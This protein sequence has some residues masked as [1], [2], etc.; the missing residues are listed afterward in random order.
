MSE[1]IY[2]C[3]LRLFP[4]PFRKQYQEEGLRLVRERLREECGFFSRLRLGFDLIVDMIRALPQAY[5]NSYP[6]AAPAASIPPPIDVLPSFQSMQR[7]PFHRGAFMLGGVFTLCALG[8]FTFALD[9][10]MPVLAGGNRPTSPV[11]AVM[12]RLNQSA[13]PE[14][15]DRADPDAPGSVSTAVLLRRQSA[16]APG[17][18]PQFEVVSIHE[19]SPDQGRSGP[20]QAEAT[21]DGYRIQGMPL[22]A[23]IQIAYIPSDGSYHYSPEQIVGLPASLSSARYDIAA[24][25]SGADLPRWNDPT[26]QPAMMRAMMQAML[27][28]RFQLEVHHSTKIVPIYEM[29][30]GRKRPKFKPT[31]GATLEQIRRQHPNARVL[32]GGII[33]ASGPNPGQQWLFGVTMPALGE[34]LS[35][36]A[37][38]PISD[39]TGLTGKYDLAYQIETPSSS[40]RASGAALP[41][42]YYSSQVFYVVQ[43]QLGL[44]LKAARGPEESLV[45]DHVESPSAN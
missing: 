15:Q 21:P 35:T 16:A 19:Q 2:A 17:S 44:K 29:T 40:Q 1:K 11:E 6:E 32:R 24:R 25:V 5:N 43:D 39:K 7:E 30:L 9:L 27:A 10:P 4:A 12:D 42:D 45:I 31:A 20:V 14:S 3:L 37:R 18:R 41:P 28:D 33:V 22:M 34:F 38:R 8:I 13:P 26:A 23:L 36:M